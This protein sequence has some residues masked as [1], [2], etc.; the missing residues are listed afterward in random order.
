MSS[1]YTR[2]EKG[3]WQAD[4]RGASRRSPIRIPECDSQS[5]IEDNK[6]TII[7][8]VTNPMVQPPKAVIGFLPQLWKLE[9]RVVDI[10]FVRERDEPLDKD[11][12]LGRI[13]VEINGFAPLEMRLPIL[14]P[15]GETTFVEL[16]YEN[17]GKHCFAC[18][19]LFHEEKFCQASKPS[20]NAP[21][22]REGISQ[23]NTLKQIEE[24]KKRLEWRKSKR[25]GEFHYQKEDTRRRRDVH[26]GYSSPH[27]SN[28]SVR[29]EHQ[30]TFSKSEQWREVPRHQTRFNDR[31]Y[32]VHRDS[33]YQSGRERRERIPCGE[34]SRNSNTSGGITSRLSP[35]HSQGGALP[36]KENTV[37]SKTP[38]PRH[39]REPM[40]S[41]L[42]RDTWE[43][44]S[45]QRERRPALERIQTESQ[46]HPLG[47]GGFSSGGL[48]EVQIQAIED[49]NQSSFYLNRLFK[50]D[51][52]GPSTALKHRLFFP[53]EDTDPTW[54]PARTAEPLNQLSNRLG[55]IPPAGGGNRSSARISNKVASSKLDKKRE[56]KNTTKRKGNANTLKG[57]NSRKRNVLRSNASPKKRK[58]GS[59]AEPDSPLM[60]NNLEPNSPH[61]L[62]S[63][64][65]MVLGLLNVKHSGNL[66]SWRG[67]RY[68]HHVKARLDRSLANVS[69]FEK[70]SHGRCQY[71]RF[72]GSDH[73][74]LI[75][76]F[77]KKKTKKKG[78]FR[79]DRTLC[80][81]EKVR[82]LVKATWKRILPDG[83]ERTKQLMPCIS[84]RFKT[85]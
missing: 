85:S 63:V 38:S 76:F 36:R 55:P 77:G 74:P 25:E 17:L 28:Y 59:R 69:W 54:T 44:T 33:A 2:N 48:Q 75:T 57:M 79:F 35:I 82:V 64:P 56:T 65:A 40:S 19:S 41:R 50:E 58:C 47:S 9:N 71:L 60:E 14:L 29:G 23:Q 46:E 4:T 12:I 32:P 37:T 11:V 18:L 80:K 13:R 78:V 16:E 61:V 6:L 51:A 26:P 22:N 30:H 72:E 10:G 52:P 5:L 73:R 21:G 1:R 62:A 15:S 67:S 20:T 3:K 45:S 24:D 43:G 7:G 8:R 27:R 42:A 39:A 53:E 81:E 68:S 70:F 31:A 84:E 49:D 66:L 83:Q 34:F